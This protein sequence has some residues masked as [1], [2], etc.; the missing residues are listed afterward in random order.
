M[1]R[2][3]VV[4][5]GVQIRDGSTHRSLVDH[6]NS[7]AKSTGT[8]TWDFPPKGTVTHTVSI[9][10]TKAE[11][12]ASLDSTD[13]YV[14]YDGHSRIGQGP[15]FGPASTPE[16]PDAAK[17]PNNPWGDNVLMGHHAVSVEMREDILQHGIDPPE[18]PVLSPIDPT[19]LLSSGVRDVIT[20][21][22]KI[23]KPKC[24]TTHAWRTLTVCDPTLAGT[25]NCRKA[26]TLA[27]RHYYRRRKAPEYDTLVLRGNSDLTPRK[28]ACAVLFMNSC[29]SAE[30]YRDPLEAQRTAV[31]SAC[32]FYFTQHVCSGP[33][34]LTFVKLV[35]AGVDPVSTTGSARYVKD[36]NGIHGSGQI[37]FVK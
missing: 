37:I 18:Y 1:A 29:S 2:S 22:Q 21:A 12:L 27:T 30:H 7:V 20:R 16:C 14:V 34:T 8:G 33:Q 11:F 13:A 9:V 26:K 36:M 25:A 35:L 31:K 6:L 19:H 5:F 3:V 10:Y 4:A 24:N 28:L 32:S 15:A 23:T 17:Y